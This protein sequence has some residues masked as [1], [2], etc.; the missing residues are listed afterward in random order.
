MMRVLLT[1]LVAIVLCFG[2]A[3]AQQV[4]TDFEEN[5]PLAKRPDYFTANKKGDSTEVWLNYMAALRSR[6]GLPSSYFRNYL[7]PDSTVQTNFTSGLGYVWKHSFGQVIHPNHTIWAE[8]GEPEIG[9]WTSYRID[10]IAIYYRYFR[11]DEDAD[12]KL[13]IQFF[14]DSKI[15][16]SYNPGWKSGASYANVPYN[17]TE[18]KGD[19]PTQEIVYTLKKSD[20]AGLTR[21]GRLVLPLRTELGTGL[22]AVTVTYF[23]GKPAGLGDTIDVYNYPDVRNKVNAFIAYDR[24]DELPYVDAG[25][26][27]NGLVISSSVRYNEN[28]NGWNGSYQPGTSWASSTGIYHFD[29][30]FKI[31]FD[32]LDN[33]LREKGRTISI[34][35]NPAK[36]VLMIDGFS[37]QTATPYQ[38][39]DIN[40]KVVLT[41]MLQSGT[42]SISELIPGAYQLKLLTAEEAIAP[43]GF[44][45]N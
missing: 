2:T 32:P 3:E 17:H 36:D 16:T 19:N 28:D 5:G 41:G 8:Y 20:T 14:D 38:I 42:I 44:L 29:M 26:Y 23:P 21:Q 24:R 1:F 6:G 9:R 43:V 30:D 27:N 25:N 39:V 35:P 7:Y 22:S 4:K 34:Y 18:R 31:V 15:R 33:G 11:F 13:V 40:G 12:D 37:N 45:R 10:S